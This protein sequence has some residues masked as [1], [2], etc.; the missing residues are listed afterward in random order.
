MSDLKQIDQDLISL[1]EN[2][3]AEPKYVQMQLSGLRDM[4]A[5]RGDA[6]GYVKVFLEDTKDLPGECIAVL[7]PGSITILTDEDGNLLEFA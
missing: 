2:F 7:T 3:R 6:Q 5:K 1:W 4:E